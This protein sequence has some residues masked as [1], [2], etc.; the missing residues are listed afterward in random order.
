VVVDRWRWVIAVQEEM[1]EQGAA[2]GQ[3][4]ERDVD[5]DVDTREK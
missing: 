1:H 4:A 2:E 3:E 5:W